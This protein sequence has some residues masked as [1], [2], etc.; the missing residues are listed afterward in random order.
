MKEMINKFKDKKNLKFSIK[1]SNKKVKVSKVFV[2]ALS[3]VSI[4]GFVGI[5]SESLFDFDL[6]YYVEALLMVIIGLALILEAKIKTLKTLTEGFNS[7]NFPRLITIII[8]AVS[9][10]AGIFSIPQIR[11]DNPAFL[12]VKGILAIIAIVII[13]IQTWIIKEI[14]Q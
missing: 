6:D 7:I 14:E 1:N 11:F 8:G 10:I 9:I 4:L 3:I 13:I 5:I 2:L 12:A